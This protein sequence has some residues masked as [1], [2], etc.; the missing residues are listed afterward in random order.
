[1]NLGIHNA[2]GAIKRREN[3]GNIFF[4]DADA[5]VFNGNFYRSIAVFGRNFQAFV[6][7]AILDGIDY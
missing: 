7:V 1:M 2:F 5:L 4:S 3:F 6:T